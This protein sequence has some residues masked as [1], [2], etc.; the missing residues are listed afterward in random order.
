IHVPAPR[1]WDSRSVSTRADPRSTYS[2]SRA[3][4]SAAA[5]C[6]AAAGCPLRGRGRSE[7][8]PGGTMPSPARVRVRASDRTG[9]HMRVQLAYGE[10]GLTVDL[11]DDRTTVVTPR[12][13]PGAEDP[14]AVL[15]SA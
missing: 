14:A 1:C 2:G 13:V 10:Q 5:S 9:D 4:P 8:G 12:Y 6:P 3:S 15:R 7:V 11:P